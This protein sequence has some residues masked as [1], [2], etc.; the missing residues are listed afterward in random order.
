MTLLEL[1]WARP[2]LEALGEMDSGINILEDPVLQPLTTR[3]RLR[4]IMVRTYDS[5]EDGDPYP[6]KFKIYYGRRMVGQFSTELADYYNVDA[7]FRMHHSVALV[8]E[9]GEAISCFPS[10]DNN[11]ISPWA[12]WYLIKV[13]ADIEELP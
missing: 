13:Y 2:A 5:S 4:G 9:K 12:G 7:V 8:A 6:M 3:R 10:W 1:V 11:G